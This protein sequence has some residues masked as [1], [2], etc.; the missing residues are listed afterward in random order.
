MM[1]FWEILRGVSM[2]FMFVVRMV[3]VADV[4]G[5]QVGAVPLLVVFPPTVASPLM[6][7]V[8][9]GKKWR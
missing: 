3:G 6:E 4:V 2:I 7:E 9:D 8:D 1:W 5:D